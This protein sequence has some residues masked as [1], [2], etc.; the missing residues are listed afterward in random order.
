[1]PTM[2]C[3]HSAALEMWVVY[4]HP[5]DFPAE[6]VARLWMIGSGQVVPRDQV[7]T[8]RSLSLLRGEM[9]ARGLTV[10]PRFEGDDPGI[11]EV[12]L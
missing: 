4:D 12:W 10:I 6:Y 8:S 9:A 11:V 5:R 2:E 3:R 7:L 1:M